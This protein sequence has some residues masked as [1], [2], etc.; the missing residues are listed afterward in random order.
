MRRFVLAILI[1]ADLF[2]AASS[3]L[4]TPPAPVPG[5]PAAGAPPA[6]APASGAPEKP[7]SPVLARELPSGPLDLYIFH[8]PGCSLCEKIV[9]LKPDMEKLSPKLRVISENNTVAGSIE[10]AQELRKESKIQA[11]IWGPSIAIFVGDGWATTEGAHLLASIHHV[12]RDR[13]EVEGR[14]WAGDSLQAVNVK[15]DRMQILGEFRAINPR[16]LLR[17]GAISGLNFPLLAAW[18]CLLALLILAGRG[19]RRT[20]ALGL[21]FWAGAVLALAAHSLGGSDF[22][23]SKLPPDFLFW[24]APAVYAILAVAAL[25]LARHW[26]RAYQ[27]APAAALP[28]AVE[29]PAPATEPAG[30]PASEGTSLAGPRPFVRRFALSGFLLGGILVFAAL[31]L[32]PPQQIAILGEVWGLGDLPGLV[33][34]YLG[35]FLATAAFLP[36][37]V[38]LVAWLVTAL[39]TVRRHFAQRPA[40]LPFAAF[41]AFLIMGCFLLAQVVTVALERLPVG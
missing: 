15:R 14:A 18:F 26:W 28:R 2:L 22:V 19:A 7:S 25:V 31:M 13:V 12:L 21:G 32:R 39:P 41:L 3:L 34:S 35:C 16:D 17:Q 37:L 6:A 9:A 38:A 27:A 11:E 23:R 36:L 30:E 4:A 1:L 40:E 10:K 8:N 5:L 33:A 24:A 20:A 29:G